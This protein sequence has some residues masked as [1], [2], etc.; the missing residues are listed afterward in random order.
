MEIELVIYSFFL[1][2]FHININ[3]VKCTQ[4]NQRIEPKWFYFV[5]KP[6]WNVIIT[7]LTL[8]KSSVKEKIKM[9]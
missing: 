9:T 7:L 3:A 2:K 1:G 5:L 6:F 8:F 4:S